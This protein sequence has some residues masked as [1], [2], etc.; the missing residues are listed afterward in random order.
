MLRA[1]G[2]ALAL[3]FVGWPLSV[4]VALGHS[5]LLRAEPPL[6]SRLKRAP[7]EIKLH[8]SEELEPAYSWVRVEDPRGSRVDRGESRVD[9]SN[10]F[11]LRA[12]LGPLAPASYKVIWRVL[13]VD[14][15]ITEGSFSFKVE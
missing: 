1:T 8:F 15:H 4:S 13:S 14:G 2:K 6:E 11:V 9:P 3:L 12:T 5:S 7:R 10:S